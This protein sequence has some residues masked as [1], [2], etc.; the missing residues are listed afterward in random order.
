MG[1]LLECGWRVRLHRQSGPHT[2]SELRLLSQGRHRE[3]TKEL[4][5]E[6][7]AELHKLNTSK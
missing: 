4:P 7:V 2:L 1:S 3:E 6:E 5:L